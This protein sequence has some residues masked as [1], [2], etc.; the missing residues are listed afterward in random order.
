MAVKSQNLAFIIVD[1]YPV[2]Y[3]VDNGKQVVLVVLQ[4]FNLIL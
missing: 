3:V 1:Q 4:R 2:A